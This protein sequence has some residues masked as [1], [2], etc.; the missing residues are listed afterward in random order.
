MTENRDS[1]L[2]LLPIH[3]ADATI[4]EVV[5]ACPECGM[6]Q[7]FRG[8]GSEISDAAEVW[9]KGHQCVPHADAKGAA[10]HKRE[11][12]ETSCHQ[13]T[14]PGE[15]IHRGVQVPDGEGQAAG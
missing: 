10:A 7:T 13:Q 6:R 14:S 15:V 4:W 8:T 5:V 3:D 11:R 2:E 9:Q 12:L 1:W